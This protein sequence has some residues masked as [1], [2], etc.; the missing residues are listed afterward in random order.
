M[1]VYLNNSER[2]S[3]KGMFHL[4][5]E[6]TNMVFTCLIWASCYLGIGSLYH[7]CD[8]DEHTYPGDWQFTES[9]HVRKHSERNYFG[10]HF[11]YQNEYQI[12]PIILTYLK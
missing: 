7:S 10:I 5:P 2:S 11:L 9:A 6:M 12:L 4:S 8:C 3:L 1:C